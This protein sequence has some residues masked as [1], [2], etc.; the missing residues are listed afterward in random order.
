MTYDEMQRT[1]MVLLNIPLNETDGAYSR[2]APAMYEYASNR[3]YRE[4]DFLQCE[5]STVGALTP[6]SRTFPV[7][8]AVI[9]IDYINIFNP[10]TLRFPLERVSL[11][12]LDFFY[13]SSLTL[14]PPVKY[15][16]MGIST[17]GP[18]ETYSQILRLGPTPDSG[19]TIEFMGRVAP[20]PLSK[21]N[22]PTFLSTNYSSLLQ[23][24]CMVFGSAAQ[25]D[26][27]AQAEDPQKAMS[28]EK[29]YTDLR[30]G[31]M[32]EVARQKGQGPGWGELAPAPI[33]NQ[34][35]AAN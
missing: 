32:L 25:R 35:R 28:W 10:S 20:A 26:F 12:A 9:V 33:A 27:G 11:H 21:L 30:E 1:L 15:A 7:P 5:T 6:A 2:Y 19:Y 4:L 22:S 17:V 8:A 16:V 13:P 31:I 14:G 29:V 34:P 23:A 24:A 3:I 18:P